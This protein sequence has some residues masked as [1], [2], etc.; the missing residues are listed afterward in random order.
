MPPAQLPP[1]TGPEP[2]PIPY[3]AAILLASGRATRMGCP[4]LLLPLAGQPLLQFALDAVS[5]SCLAEVVLVVGP[6]VRSRLDELSLPTGT[7]LTVVENPDPDAGQS[8]SL[9]LGL[10][11]TSPR[12]VAAAI[13]LGDEPQLDPG[14][15]DSMARIFRSAEKPAARPVYCSPPESRVPGH[16][17][18]VARRLW[19]EIGELRGDQG[20]RDWLSNRPETLLEVENQGPAPRDI[21]TWEDYRAAGGTAPAAN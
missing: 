11:A 5:A 17:V 12:A 14:R 6:E 8:H 20:L 16:P 13:V 2:V 10:E 9:R 4:K 21:D 7:P 3:Y 1:S 19:T 15:I 18:F